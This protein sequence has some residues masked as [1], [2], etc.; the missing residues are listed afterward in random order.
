MFYRTSGVWLG[1]ILTENFPVTFLGTKI[2]V[3]YSVATHVPY[4]VKRVSQKFFNN[5][6]NFFYLF[7]RIPNKS[8]KLFN[9][10]DEGYRYRY[11]LY[12][13]Y[14]RGRREI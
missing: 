3:P 14:R 7:M 13:Y 1:T 9:F 5:I 8:A 12:C 6:P 10:Y 2:S 4:S 11:Y